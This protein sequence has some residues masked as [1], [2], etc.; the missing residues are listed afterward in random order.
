[1][2]HTLSH[3]NN[4]AVAV[5]HRFWCH[6]AP[7]SCVVTWHSLP[8]SGPSAGSSPWLR[9]VVG[10]SVFC[11]PT[12]GLGWQHAASDYTPAVAHLSCCEIESGRRDDRWYYGNSSYQ[13]EDLIKLQIL[14]C[15][16]SV[17]SA[18]LIC[19]WKPALLLFMSGLN[20]ILC[21]QVASNVNVLRSPTCPLCLP[22]LTLTWYLNHTVWLLS[23]RNASYCKCILQFS[24]FYWGRPPLFMVELVGTALFFCWQTPEWLC[25]SCNRRAPPSSDHKH[26]TSLPFLRSGQPLFSHYSLADVKVSLDKKCWSVLSAQGP[27]LNLSFINQLAC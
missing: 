20:N 5:Q 15:V 2:R 25:V 4:H 13:C 7:V 6:L 1:M 27:V 11:S 12:V 3:K 16:R 14:S 10:L 8:V 17:G 18:L 26:I 9:P 19:S 24:P 23:L 22:S 21:C